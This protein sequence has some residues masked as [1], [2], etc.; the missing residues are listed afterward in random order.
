VEKFFRWM[1]KMDKEIRNR[2]QQMLGV[3]D[4]ANPTLCAAQ[5]REFWLTFDPN[6]GIQ[7]VKAEQR[8]QYEATGTPVP[9]LKEI[10]TQIV[11]ATGKDVAY[12]LPFA[13]V[14]WDQY[15]RE[16]RIVSLI[17][18][19]ALE[20][21]D[22]QR[23]VPLLKTMCR[24]C[25]S[26]EDADRLAMDA[27]EPIVRKDPTTWFGEL[28]TWLTDESPWNRR[29]AITVIARLPMKQPAFVGRCIAA[30][31]ILLNDAEL[32]VK[33]AVSFAL[34]ICAK[35]AP[36]Q[37]MTFLRDHI[38]PPDPAA[39]WV[40]CDVIKSLDKKLLTQF[41]ALRPLYEQWMAQPGMTAKDQRTIVSAIKLLC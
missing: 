7:L 41:A 23:I 31:E 11:K 8:A 12:F 36:V 18:F 2:V 13:Q 39:T 26:W 30:C 5:L 28:E 14:L 25:V 38:P 33:R 3:Y 32:D 1:A 4:A 9:V 10:A 6:Q 40:L 15:G 22:P 27:L 35:T 29:A 37:V 20:L 24:Q 21:A 16:G 34:R 17:I 19:G